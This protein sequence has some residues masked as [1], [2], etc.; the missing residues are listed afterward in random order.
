MKEPTFLLI[1]W[2]APDPEETGTGE[3][4]AFL[5]RHHRNEIAA[6]FPAARGRRGLGQSCDLCDGRGPR[7]AAPGRDGIQ[8]RRS[9]AAL[10]PGGRRGLA[11]GP[12]S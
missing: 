7:M 6:T 11:H 3:L 4:E 1:A 2:P 10:S 12:T 9:C 8:G 5:C